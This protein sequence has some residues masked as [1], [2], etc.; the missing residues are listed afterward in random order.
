MA[1]EVGSESRGKEIV[2]LNGWDLRKPTHAHF[3]ISVKEKIKNTPLCL[4]DRRGS[5]PH[6]QCSTVFGGLAGPR[7]GGR[8]EGRDLEDWLDAER[9]LVAASST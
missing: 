2:L 6:D 1:S 9:Q 4:A 7:Q 3:Y 8:Q 5:G